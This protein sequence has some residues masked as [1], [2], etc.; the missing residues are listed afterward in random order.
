M[1][2]GLAALLMI[3]AAGCYAKPS[4]ETLIETIRTDL[5]REPEAPELDFSEIQIPSASGRRTAVIIWNADKS[6]QRN[7][8]VVCGG[9]E[10][11]CVVEQVETSRLENGSYRRIANDDGRLTETA[12]KFDPIRYEGKAFACFRTEIP[13]SSFETVELDGEKNLLIIPRYQ[14]VTILIRTLEWKNGNQMESGEELARYDK[15]VNLLSGFDAHPQ[16]ELSVE[17]GGRT[18]VIPLT[19]SFYDSLPTLKQED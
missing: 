4:E 17:S 16:F 1:K 19:E 2:K 13:D 18:T 11:S 10:D 12:R 9:K 8:I 6:I 14:D 7:Y 15:P 5:M 3:G